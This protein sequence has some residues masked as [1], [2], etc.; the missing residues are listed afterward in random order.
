LTLNIWAPAGANPGDLP[1]M[2]WI[3]GGGYMLGSG[4][5]PQFDGTSLARKGEV[6]VTVNYRLG[7]LGF[8]AHPGLSE[9]ARYNAP[10][11]SGSLD[12]IAGLKWVQATVA[13]F[14]GE[15]DNVTIFGES[16]GAGSVHILQAS[17]LGEGLFAKVIGQ[18]TSQF[19]P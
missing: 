14:G 19:D 11:I 4:R 8:M 6:L 2:V 7:P 10:G 5:Q 13:A 1:V 17:P 12:Q 9:S 15:P 3:H 18:S 16:A